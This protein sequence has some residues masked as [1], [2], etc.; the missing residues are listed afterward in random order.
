MLYVDFSYEPLGENTA[1]LN[2]RGPSVTRA[3][4]RYTEVLSAVLSLSEDMQP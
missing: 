1:K 3:G 4:E 2:Y